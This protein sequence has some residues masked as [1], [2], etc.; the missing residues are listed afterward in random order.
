MEFKFQYR[1]I[2]YRFPGF[3]CCKE[4][5]VAV[6]VVVVERENAVLQRCIFSTLTCESR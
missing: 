4:T 3:Q 1:I 2:S 6:V 5:V